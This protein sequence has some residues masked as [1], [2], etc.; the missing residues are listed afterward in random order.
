MCKGVY[1]FYT[2]KHTKS[3]VVNLSYDMQ[4][5]T[6]LIFFLKTFFL[7]LFLKCKFNV[8]LSSMSKH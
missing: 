2:R 3:R 1:M 4:N 6:I 8:K 5:Q 7:K